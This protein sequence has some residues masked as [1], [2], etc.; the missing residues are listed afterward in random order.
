MPCGSTVLADLDRGTLN[1]IGVPGMGLSYCVRS[2]FTVE[3]ASNDLRE[4][5]PDRARARG[6]DLDRYPALTGLPEPSST[7]SV[8]R[9]DRVPDPSLLPH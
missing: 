4:F 3:P 7:L 6:N 9:P 5:R 2:T 8:D 1:V